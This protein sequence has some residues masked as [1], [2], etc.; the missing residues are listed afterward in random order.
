MKSGW[1]QS[2][3]PYGNGYGGPGYAVKSEASAQ[4]GPKGYHDKGTIA[5]SG[6]LKNNF[7][8][9]QFFIALDRVDSFDRKFT[10]IGRIDANGLQHVEKIGKVRVDRSTDRPFED[11]ELTKVTIVVK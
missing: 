2:G 10:I 8:G 3:C 5:M 9:S 7:S 11:V 4:E 6:Y 1:I